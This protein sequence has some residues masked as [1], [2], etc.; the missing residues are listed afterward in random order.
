MNRR[1]NNANRMTTATLNLLDDHEEI[2]IEFA[3]IAAQ[4]TRIAELQTQ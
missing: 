4:K 3:V 1:Q 2:W